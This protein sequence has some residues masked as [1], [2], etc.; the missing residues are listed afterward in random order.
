VILADQAAENLPTLDP[1]SDIDGVAML[2]LRR[3]LLQA[4]MR[5][6]AVVVPGV[7]G[8]DAAEVLLAEDQHVVQ[9]LAPQC[10][11]E[12]FRV[13]VIPHRQL[14]LIRMIGTGASG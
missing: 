2:L 8:Q 3:F 4:L 1:G 12:A 5:T 11:H 10:S 6:V 13:G 9:A 14:R 7:L